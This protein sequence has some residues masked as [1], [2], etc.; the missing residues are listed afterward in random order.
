M[1]T[2][3]HLLGYN[4]RNKVLTGLDGFNNFTCDLYCH[5]L[6]N[7]KLNLNMTY[8]LKGFYVPHWQ[9]MYFILMILLLLNVGLDRTWNFGMRK[10]SGGGWFLTIPLK[11]AQNTPWNA[12]SMTW[13]PPPKEYLLREIGGWENW[14]KI[15]PTPCRNSRWDPTPG[16]KINQV[17]KTQKFYKWRHFLIPA[18]RSCGV[19]LM[20]VQLTTTPSPAKASAVVGPMAANWKD[21]VIIQYR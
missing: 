20:A 6:Y 9:T 11:A 3:S 17:G 8:I 21:S 13:W 1:W 10:G 15:T 16:L 2:L 18:A 5:S 14:W 19:G 12:A 4:I 7:I